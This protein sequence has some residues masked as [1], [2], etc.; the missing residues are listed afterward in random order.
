MTNRW[1]GTIAAALILAL[2]LVVA[3]S[4]CDRAGEAEVAGM[5]VAAPERPQDAAK[6]CEATLPSDP[7]QRCA[8]RALRGDFGPLKPWQEEAYRLGLERGVMVQGRVFLTAYYP[9][10]GRSGR[11]DCRGN[12]CSPRTAAANRLPYGSYVW[13]ANP[14]GV[15]QV[16]DRGARSNDRIADR[17]GCDLW[18]DL[19]MTR[20]MGTR[21]T[22]YAVIGRSR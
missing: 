6:C 10:E 22:V 21:V 8:M 16:L 13:V 20:R 9:W 12:P 1:Q 11:V 7:F 3:F 2:P 18:L 14:C 4:R 17:R 5:A 15:R 19:W